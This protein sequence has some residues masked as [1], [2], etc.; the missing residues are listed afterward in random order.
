MIA[1]L[2][3]SISDQALSMPRP[4]SSRQEVLRGGHQRPRGNFFTPHGGEFGGGHRDNVGGD[5]AIL[6]A[7]DVSTDEPYSDVPA[8]R[9]ECT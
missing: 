4:E 8:S 3:P 7:F 2:V 1:I 9:V 5:L 6:R